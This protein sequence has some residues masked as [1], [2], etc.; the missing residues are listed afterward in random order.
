M[1]AQ[2]GRLDA[3]SL[4]FIFPQCY[5]HHV[6]QCCWERSIPCFGW[7]SIDLELHVTLNSYYSQFATTIE[8][9]KNVHD[10]DYLFSYY[11]SFKSL[12]LASSFSLHNRPSRFTF[13][14]FSVVSC[15]FRTMLICLSWL[16]TKYFSQLEHRA[17]PN[18]KNGLGQI[19]RECLP[20]GK[21]HA[22]VIFLSFLGCYFIH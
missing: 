6:M 7:I 15:V 8:I 12:E 3:T 1:K 2:G 16:R 13:S 14:S 21:F 20:A 22:H 18:F 4:N 19:P 17:N 10:V 9:N 11:T 5:A